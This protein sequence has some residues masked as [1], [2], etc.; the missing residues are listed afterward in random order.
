MYIPKE[1]YKIKKIMFITLLS[2]P[3][4]A[5][6]FDLYNTAAYRNANE[7]YNTARRSESAEAHKKLCE[8]N[9]GL[10]CAVLGVYYQKGDGVNQNKLKAADLYKKACDLGV[11]NGCQNLQWLNQ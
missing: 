3:I 5:D 2:M 6:S 1:G 9:N 7:L 4:F 10:S 8:A 11:D